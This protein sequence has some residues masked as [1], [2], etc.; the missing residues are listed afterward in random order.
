[1]LKRI[2]LLVFT[3]LLF[4]LFF[5]LHK[6]AFLL[7]HWNQ[8]GKETI[9]NLIQVILSGFQMDLSV[10]GYFTILPLLVLLASVCF[11]GKIFGRILQVY[12]LIISIVLAMI[13]IGDMVLFSFWNFRMDASVFLYLSKPKEV[14]ASVPYWQAA[15]GFLCVA[16]VAFIQYLLLN[17]LVA[18]PLVKSERSNQRIIES[19]VIFLLFVP[20]FIGIRGGIYTS[21]MNMGRVY[22]SQ[23]MF[24]NQSAVNPVFSII[25]SLSHQEKF[26]SQYRFMNDERA[27]E[28]FNN[29]MR[30]D[31]NQQCDSVLRTTRPNIVFILLESFG[32]DMIEPLGGLKGVTPNLNKLTEESIVFTHM[33]ANSFR[34]DRGLVA[35][36]AGFPAQ[37]NMSI[38]SYANKCTSLNSIPKVLTEHGYKTS[39]TYGGDVDF[40]NMKTYLIS[41][42]VVDIQGVYDFPKEENIGRWGVPDHFAF[43]HFE[44]Q[45]LEQKETPFFKMFLS[46]SSH[47]PFE[48][49][50]HKFEHPYVNSVAYS[51]SCLGIF[52]N[53]LKKSPL[54]KNTLVILVPDHD[55]GYP[56][57]IRHYVPKRHNIFMIWTGGAIACPL[58]INRI[59]SQ[60]DIAA[61]LLAQMKIDYKD[62]PF[63]KD[64]LNPCAPEFAFY[65]FN[66]GFGM[67]TPEGKW[68]Y[69]CNW[70]YIIQPR[71]RRNKSEAVEQ[72]KAFLQCLYDDIAKK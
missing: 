69:D 29:M 42:K 11:R 52:I 54:W 33:Y 35:T 6:V 53:N 2:R 36:T 32:A 43:K 20:L 66:N 41:Q 39:F 56:D 48:V 1:M 8:S 59:C 27:H 23:N 72:G 17:I 49:P 10:A 31:R 51:D 13:V 18:K 71:R 60:S 67:V 9:D 61:T 46:L 68:T 70:N 14:L 63:S 38:I 28:I 19:I 37:P 64:I 3:Y 15:V 34:T 65:A 45:V 12:F 4:L 25:Y 57:G 5:I 44:K 21:T 24:L 26:E 22:F 55:M 58:Q 16:V 62:F 7:Y 47:E 30:Y 50:M 40:A